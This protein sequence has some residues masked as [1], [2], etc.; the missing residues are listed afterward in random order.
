MLVRTNGN[1][2]VKCIP[3]LPF[4]PASAKSLDLVPISHAMS[5]PVV[6]LPERVPL[7]VLRGVLRTTRHNGFPVVQATAAGQVLS[8]LNFMDTA[9]T[10]VLAL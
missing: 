9:A 7:R 2:Q 6:T 1:L 10:C 8:C 4:T 3:W 5:F